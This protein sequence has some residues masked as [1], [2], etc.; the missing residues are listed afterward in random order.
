MRRRLDTSIE[1]SATQFATFVR[2]T[3]LSAPGTVTSNKSKA[4]FLFSSQ[5]LGKQQ[6]YLWTFRFKDLLGVKE[7]RKRWNHLLSLLLR[8]WPDLQ[9][10]RVFELHEEHGLHVH[11]ATNQFID[12][13][14]ARKLALRPGWGRIHV[15]RM[16]SEHAGYL[17]EER[18]ECLHQWR[19]WAGFGKSLGMDA[20]ERRCAGNAVQ[21]HLRGLQR[22]ER[23]EGKERVS[24]T[25]GSCSSHHDRDHRKRLG[26]RLRTRRTTIL[27]MQ[28]CIRSRLTTKLSYPDP[29]IKLWSDVGGEAGRSC[30]GGQRLAALHG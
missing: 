17:S 15:T 21:P 5:R 12:V 3:W 11:L 18:P 4:A 28:R 2:F 25:Y 27:R 19:L 26:C 8:T 23:L 30:E 9:G 14:R 16:P 29:M 22:V 13:N 24:R 1:S 7:T 20:S 6:L 10:L